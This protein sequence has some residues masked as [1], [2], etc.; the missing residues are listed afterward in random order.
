MARHT[1]GLSLTDWTMTLGAE[2]Q[3]LVA[4]GA[5]VTFWSAQVGGVQHLDLLDAAGAAV[6]SITSADGAGALPKG[7]IAQFS[8]PDNITELWADAGGGT[9]YK[10]LATDLGSAVTDLDNRVTA[11]ETAVAELDTVPVWVRRDPAT[12]GWPNRPPTGRPCIWLD[13]Q[14]L[15]PSPPAIG[16]TGMAEGLD[17]YWGGA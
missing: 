6:T 16:G 1:F 14:P 10:M 11:L 5:V 12:G 9:R 17:Q 7:T 13:T 2:D 8:G 4:G 15:T 3:V